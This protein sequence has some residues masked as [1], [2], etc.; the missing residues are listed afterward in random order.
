MS[1]ALQT[2]TVTEGSI[3]VTVT[4]ATFLIDFKRAVLAQEWE[5]APE[6]KAE[7]VDELLAYFAKA[8]YPTVVSATA[9][10]EGMPWPPKDF[11]ELAA[12]RSGPQ[13]RAIFAA[14]N[15]IMELNPDWNPV[16]EPAEADP[17]KAEPP[18]ES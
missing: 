13:S 18:A 10:V 6:S 1:E 17:K 11:R 16:G 2:R 7:P 12:V 5:N 4:E 9:G 8:I 15:A 14:Y 3:S